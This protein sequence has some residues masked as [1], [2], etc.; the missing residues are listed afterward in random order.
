MNPSPHPANLVIRS[1]VR[2]MRVP[3]KQ[4]AELLAFAAGREKV[5]LGEVDISIVSGAEMARINRRFLAHRGATD[6]I[7]F[8]LSD[9]FVPGLSMQVVVCAD[10]AR[11]VGPA[12]GNTP[13]RELLLYV[14]HGLLHVIGYDDQNPRAAARMHARQD[15][16][17]GEFLSPGRRSVR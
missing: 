5:R 6:V 8:D 4:I 7:S 10:V 2:G 14:L 12:H 11:Q 3:R 17:L 16:L 9:E 15:E 1:S 13:T